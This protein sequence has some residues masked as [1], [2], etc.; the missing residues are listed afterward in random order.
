VGVVGLPKCERGVALGGNDDSEEA[1]L[2][3][4]S[5]S[6]KNFFI[7]C[8]PIEDFEPVDEALVITEATDGRRSSD[9]K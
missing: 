7:I 3:L 8:L 2:S 4:L 5:P 6:P 9:G 1:G